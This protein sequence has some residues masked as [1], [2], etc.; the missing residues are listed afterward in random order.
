M[1]KGNNTSFTSHIEQLD[2]YQSIFRTG[3][4]AE[5]AGVRGTSTND[6]S[7]T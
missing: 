1:E 5:Y 3:I 2:N 7:E 6:E 4:G